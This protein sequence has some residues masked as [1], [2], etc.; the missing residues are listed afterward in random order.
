MCEHLNKSILQP[1]QVHVIFRDC[2]CYPLA[3]KKL[4]EHLHCDN[5]FDNLEK[6]PLID[7]FSSEFQSISFELNRLMIIHWKNS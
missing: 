5:G 1:N 7:R 2:E 6:F 3:K 4:K